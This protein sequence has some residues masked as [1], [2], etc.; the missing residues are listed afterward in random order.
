VKIVPSASTY[1][2]TDTTEVTYKKHNVLL[3][4]LFFIMLLSLS[5]NGI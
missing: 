5:L 1:L 2:D 4:L 3:L